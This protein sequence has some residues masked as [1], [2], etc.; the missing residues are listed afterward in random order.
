[1]RFEPLSRAVVSVQDLEGAIYGYVDHHNK[2]GRN[3]RAQHQTIEL[4]NDIPSDFQYRS[5]GEAYEN[6]ISS[7]IGG[8]GGGRTSF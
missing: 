4:T 5:L 7:W 6:E 2:N 1:M 8:D 3:D